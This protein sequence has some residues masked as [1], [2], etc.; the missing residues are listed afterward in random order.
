LNAFLEC[1]AP[2]KIVKHLRNDPELA[3]SLEGLS[4]TRLGRKLQQIESELLAPKKTVSSAP[5]P[6]RPVSAS[7]RGV[8]DA[9]DMDIDEL[10]AEAKRGKR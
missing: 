9:G 5:A 7:G 8:K 1:D 2:A 4:P 3:A 10:W 6:V